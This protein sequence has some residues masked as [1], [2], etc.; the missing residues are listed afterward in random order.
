MTRSD[1]SH[2]RD[3]L[4]SRYPAM[5]G[6][7]AGYRSGS[8]EV[9]DGW[10]EI[11]ETAVER[12]AEAIRHRPGTS[13][14]I[15]QIKEKFGELRL[16]T[17]GSYMADEKVRMQIELVVDLA[18]ARSRCTCEV[19][20]AE[21]RLFDSGA[22]LATACDQHAIGDPVAVRSGHEGL[23]VKRQLRDGD[24]KI[25]SCRRY[26]RASD[27]FVDVDPADVGLSD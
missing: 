25:V 10:R 7:H 14:T 23:V 2:W 11:I 13:L 20:G 17:H 24:V 18:Q 16:Y 4:I 5:F 3:D 15:D 1:D 27:A 26:S 9:G 12:L 19:C 8:P 21:G 22:W 6:A